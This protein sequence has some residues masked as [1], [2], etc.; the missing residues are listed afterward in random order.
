VARWIS[1]ATGSD[2][3]AR[4][5]AI[6]AL[7]NA[8]KAQALPV[9]RKVLEVGDPEVDRQLALSSLHALAL[10]QGDT[11]GRIRKALRDA[12]YHGDDDSVGQ[13]AQTIL[14]DIERNPAGKR[15]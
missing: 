6:T 15:R 3:A 11:D 8:P 10:D 5:E 14:E 13:G 1:A 2:A 7:G 9:L 4:A 12:V